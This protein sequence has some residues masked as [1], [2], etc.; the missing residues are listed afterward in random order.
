MEDLQAETDHS[1]NGREK[2]EKKISTVF[3]TILQ[4][5]LGGGDLQNQKQ[6]RKKLKIMKESCVCMRR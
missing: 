4:L 6:E 3:F 5:R 2:I 1:I